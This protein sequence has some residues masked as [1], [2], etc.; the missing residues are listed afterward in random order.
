VHAPLHH[1]TTPPLQFGHASARPNR[2][3]RRPTQF[4]PWC[5]TTSEWRVVSRDADILQPAIT[6]LD[7]I[8][9]VVIWCQ[10]NVKLR[11]GHGDDAEAVPTFMYSPAE[12]HRLIQSQDGLWTVIT[13]GHIPSLAFEHQFR[14]CT[15]FAPTIQAPGYFRPSTLISPPDRSC[16]RRMS[17][18]CCTAGTLETFRP[19]SESFALFCPLATVSNCEQGLVVEVLG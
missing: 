4:P 2:S 14:Q 15:P 12:A 6:V 16:N 8:Q 9:R 19:S 1:S 13:A 3:A 5:W 11:F 7:R 18:V 17:K 10:D